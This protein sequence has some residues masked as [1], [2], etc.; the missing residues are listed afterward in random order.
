LVCE[1]C[2]SVYN[3]DD[4][5]DETFGHGE[6]VCEDRNT[7]EV[8]K[9]RCRTKKPIITK[10]S[11]KCS[12]DYVEVYDAENQ[13]LISRLE[14]VKEDPKKLN[15]QIVFDE[16]EYCT[17][18]YDNVKNN[19]EEGVDCGGS[20]GSCEA[21]LRTVPLFAEEV[22]EI[23][24][25]VL[26][27]EDLEEIFNAVQN[28]FF[29]VT[30]NVSCISGDCGKVEVSLDPVDWWS[31]NFGYRKSITIDNSKVD[32]DLIDFPLYVYFNDPDISKGLS[33]GYDIR[34]IDEAGNELSYERESHEVVGGNAVGN[35][36]VKIP[37]IKGFYDLIDNEGSQFSYSGPWLKSSRRQGYNGVRY[38][39]GKKSSDKAYWNFENLDNREYEVYATWSTHKNRATDSP[40]TV[41]DGDQKL[42]TTDL[43]Q[44]IEPDDLAYKGVGWELIG[45]YNIT[46]NNLTVML[47]GDADEYVI[48]D[49]ILIK[50][51]GVDNPVIYVYYGNR[52]LVDNG[53]DKINVWNDNFEG[54]WHLSDLSDSTG[55]NNNLS[56]SGSPDLQA[57]KIGNSYNFDGSKTENLNIISTLSLEGQPFSVSCWFNSNNNLEKQDILAIYDSQPYTWTK[58]QARGDLDDKVRMAEQAGCCWD[59]GA[60]SK[61][62]YTI[63]NW[64]FIGGN[65]WKIS[66]AY[67]YTW[68][69]LDGEDKGTDAHIIGAVEDAVSMYIGYKFYGSVDEC[70]VYNINRT[71]EWI[72]FEYYNINEEDNELNFGI[73]EARIGLRDSEKGLVSMEE[74]DTPFYTT[75]TNPFISGTLEE[76][77]SE[78]LVFWINAT[79]ELDSIYEF[80]TYANLLN[81][82]NVEDVTDMWE[83]KIIREEVETESDFE[84]SSE[85]DCV[86]DYYNNT[87]CMG[88]N[89]YHNFYNFSCINNSCDEEITLELV[90]A[91]ANTCVGGECVEADGGDG[92]DDGGNGGGGG[93]EEEVEET[94]FI[95]EHIEEEVVSLESN[96]SIISET[97]EEELEDELFLK[98]IFSLEKSY[99]WISLVILLF[100]IAFLL[101]KRKMHF[102]DEHFYIQDI[103]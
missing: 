79:G 43:N 98:D 8:K 31:L 86:L 93:D 37:E 45:V 65:T 26:N 59:D 41:Y 60:L 51:T 78:N 32:E 68:V 67:M 19:D 4:I 33:N 9:F 61:T 70:R 15:I 2:E 44:E 18:C 100:I 53:E 20:C 99:W 94:E 101:W 96:D 76:G 84:C 73:E 29:N 74:G 23:N 49:A 48:A 46:T 36:W 35:Y 58:L 62:S 95:E 52:T 3:L 10:L 50:K 30:L 91:C 40:Y 102:D 11:T 7:G 22:S 24:L 89:I 97:P 5:I 103:H 54:V 69:Y 72:K 21:V 16:G 56:I 71:D 77:E 13:D 88:D 1:K 63:N 28:K 27:P 55:N 92:G 87:R 75:T 34:F 25:D 6:Q 82:L 47:T 14:L 57:G 64:H 66:G 80:F 85:L 83:V 90:E 39:S 17:S 42:G 38:N 12:K 81:D